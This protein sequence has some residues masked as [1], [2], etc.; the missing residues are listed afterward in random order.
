MTLTSV[1][2]LIQLGNAHADA[3]EAVREIA[4]TTK[5]HNRKALISSLNTELLIGCRKAV[6]E[7]GM[8]CDGDDARSILY[9]I[10]EEILKRYE[11]DIKDRRSIEKA[12]DELEDRNGRFA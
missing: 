2:T 5:S 8:Y 10:T 3:L 12:K 9:E 1:I 6:S 7:L 11:A 4:S